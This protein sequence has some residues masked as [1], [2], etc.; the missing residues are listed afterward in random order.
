MTWNN[1][2]AYFFRGS[3]YMRYDMAADAVDTG[4]PKLIASGW[5]G[6]P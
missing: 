4:Y 6:L 5:P 1:G 2:K 3:E